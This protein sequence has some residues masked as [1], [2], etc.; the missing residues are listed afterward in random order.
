MR[1]LIRHL[2]RAAFLAASAARVRYCRLAFPNVTITG[3]TIGP[4]CEIHAG[5]GAR[6]VLDGVVIGRGCQLIAGPGA[7]LHIA[8][9]SVGPHSVV[10][11]RER[12]EIGDG[13]LL[14]EMVVVRDADHDRTG[15]L[16]LRAGRHRT[17][18]VHIG[19]DVWLGARATV[20]SGVRIGAGAT[21]G[22]G[23]VVTRDVAAGTTVAGVPASP[24]RTTSLTGGSS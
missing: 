7:C 20:L 24:V 17:A 1:K 12:I 6:I 11:A 19:P 14:A 23:A 4:G 9:E 3:S 10:V 13:A 16:P 21:V 2:R 8:A 15:G 5:E 22:A 18:S